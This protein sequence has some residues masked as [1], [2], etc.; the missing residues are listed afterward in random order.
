MFEDLLV[1]ISRFIARRPGVVV[2]AIALILIFSAISASNVRFTS[3]E[4]KE[5]FPPGDKVFAQSQLY[6]KD[7]GVR[8]E[9]AFIY[10]K[11]EDVTDREVLEYM[12]ELEKNLKRLDGVGSTISPASIVV[13][14][15]GSLPQD[16]ALLQQLLEFYAK[17]L[18]P[19]PTMAL[20]T[21]EITTTSPEKTNELAE[22][23]ERVI[24][25]TPRPT[26][27]IAQATGT[28][29]LGYQIVETTKKNTGRMTGISIVLM[30]VILGLTFSGVVRKKYI[31]F[32]PLII[33]VFSVMI[34]VGLLPILGI[35]LTMDISAT[36][37]ILIGLSIEYAAQVQNRFEEER[38][39]GKKRDEA[40]VLSVSRTGLAVVLAMLTTII[41][42]MSMTV[43]GMPMLTKFGLIMS[44]GLIF[45]YI[46]A[47]TFLPSVLTILDRNKERSERK[48]SKSRKELRK[49]EG[50]KETKIDEKKD[51]Y[52]ILERSLIV[53]SGVTVSNPRKIIALAVILIIFGAYANSQIK[54]ETDT[55]KW[56]PQDLP[57][58]VKFRELE[59][60]M[61]GQ[62]I[63]TL[64]LT[65][66]EINSETLKRSDELAR[67]I[68]NKEGL[69][70][71][72]MSLS[73]VLKEFASGL[74]EDD[75]KL[76]VIMDMFPEK[77]L[78]RYVSGKMMTIQLYTNA[79]THEKRLDL[80]EN[81]KKDI[82]YFGWDGKYYITGTPA[83]MAHLGQIMY[84][85]Q[86]TMTVAAYILIV[87]LL[88]AVYRSLKKA[89]IPLLAISTVIGATNTFMYFL[90]IKQTMIS[91]TLNAII[92][93]LGIDFSIMV[94]ERYHEERA[95]LSPVGAVR[96]AIEKTG[97]AVVTSAFTMAGGFGAVVFSDFPALSDFG[98]MALIAI[99]FALISALTVVPAFLMLTEKVDLNINFKNANFLNR[100][101]KIKIEN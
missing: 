13:E 86:L 3:T 19:K 4:Y 83:I 75:S 73:S 46:L 17:D 7:F 41:G 84:G 54:L 63:F 94:S 21:V 8:A 95:R 49:S 44:M 96:R 71:D 91:I 85:S 33:S 30:V 12:L 60:V 18:I 35:Q 92:L 16:E 82:Q 101:N 64:V 25:F 5:Y 52:G 55:K 53:V 97:K 61:G 93:G 38:R 23:I 77:Q 79:N 34:I 100:R 78:K 59:R 50:K 98:L 72:Y 68:V 39:E 15:Y 81:L 51:E 47:I 57:A 43:P 99:I 27:V 58:I 6:E 89:V 69:V 40:V 45:A 11:G 28:P 1:K 70:Y 74:P 42:F 22:K 67:Y 87:S 14:V 66:D 10:I 9:S 90:G 80:V 31:A 2:S 56:F 37:P 29:M 26:G 76:S 88:L 32:M 65:S 62:Y 20:I 24:Q 36:L 48:E